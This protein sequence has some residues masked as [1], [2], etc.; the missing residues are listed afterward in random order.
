MSDE[1]AQDEEDA[2]DYDM[3]ALEERGQPHP[4]NA[5]GVPEA[6]R[7]SRRRVGEDELVFEIGD[8]EDDDDGRGRTPMSKRTRPSGENGREEYEQEGLMDARR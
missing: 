2:E 4:L 8:D 7:T 3:D 6:P 5:D 1:L